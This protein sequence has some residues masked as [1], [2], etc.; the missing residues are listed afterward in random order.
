MYGSLSP[1][2]ANSTALH[3]V[4]ADCRSC[5]ENVG[6]CTAMEAARSSDCTDCSPTPGVS[7]PMLLAELSAA[8]VVST[9]PEDLG[10]RLALTLPCM[11]R[12]NILR[13]RIRYAADDARS[14]RAPP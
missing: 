12:S 9:A 10:E 2:D 6:C 14:F 5:S 11:P 7:S 8:V 1:R 13:T 3:T 4:I